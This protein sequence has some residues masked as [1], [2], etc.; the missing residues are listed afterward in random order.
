M[1]SKMNKNKSMYLNYYIEKY[2]NLVFVFEM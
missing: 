1:A 2:T